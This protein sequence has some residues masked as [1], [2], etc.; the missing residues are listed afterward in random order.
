MKKDILLLLVVTVATLLVALGLIHRYAPQL[1]GAP[2][3]LQLVALDKKLPAFYAGALRAPENS[4]DFLLKDPLTRVRGRPFYPVMPGV[5]PHDML[6]F[7]NAGVPDTADI[8]TI[9][10]S[11]T[12]G[13]NAFMEQ[14]WPAWMQAAL[15]R[16]EVNVYNMSIGGWTAIQYLDMMDYAPR[17]RPYAVV[18]AF[19]TGNDPLEA[20]QMV[21]GNDNWH[22]LMDTDGITASGLPKFSL[23]VP[24]Q[25]QWPVRFADGVHTVFTPQLRLISNTRH[26]ATDAGYAILARAAGLMAEKAGKAGVQLIFT[27]IPTKELAFARKVEAEGLEAPPQ[28]RDLVAAETGRIQTLAAELGALPGARYVDVVE[29]LQQAALGSVA[30]YPENINGHPVAAGYRVIG[31]RIATAVAGRVPEPY[32]GLYVESSGKQYFPILVSRAGVWHIAAQSV[33]QQ[34]GWPD[35]SKATVADPRRLARL[36]QLGSLNR[37]DPPHFG[38]A[39]CQDTPA[40]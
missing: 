29:P 38:P 34:N 14:N 17:F 27:I 23:D 8:I 6:G 4:K 35:G 32:C 36:P 2:P 18:V 15:Q 10:D 21:K 37:V 33:L 3:D 1:L 7:R 25:E 5:G 40:G 24:P 28:Y 26:P 12:Y 19:Y 22:W 30:L 16:P 9:G 31:E 13:N 39:M 11:M 20:F